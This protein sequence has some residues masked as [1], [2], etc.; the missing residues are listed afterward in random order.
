MQEE[1]KEDVLVVACTTVAHE[2]T[3]DNTDTTCWTFAVQL[4]PTKGSPRVLEMQEEVRE[5]LLVEECVERKG[6]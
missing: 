3:R 4:L 1:V 6:R 2:T 5:E